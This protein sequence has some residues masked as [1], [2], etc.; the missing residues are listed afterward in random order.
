MLINISFVAAAGSVPAEAPYQII[1]VHT[2][3]PY[4]NFSREFQYIHFRYGFLIQ[5]ILKRLFKETLVHYYG[6][7][8][9][10]EFEYQII[11]QP[12]KKRFNTIFLY[13]K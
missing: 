9:L 6:I 13:I 12:S 7:L 11:I 8:I 2:K 10:N 1:L 4:K 5:Y 3:P